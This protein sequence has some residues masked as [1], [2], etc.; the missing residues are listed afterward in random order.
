MNVI[1]KLVF[2]FVLASMLSACSTKIIQS[3]LVAVGLDSKGAMY[4]PSLE[5]DKRFIEADKLRLASELAILSN[6][7]YCDRTDLTL[8][9]CDNDTVLLQVLGGWTPI[10]EVEIAN[11]SKWY[12]LK[13]SRG[14]RMETWKKKDIDGKEVAAIVIRGTVFNEI[15][16]W[17][18]NLRWITRINPFVFDQYDQVRYNIRDIVKDLETSDRII[19]TGHSLGGG[20]AQ[21]AAYAS[22]RIKEVYAF[23]PSPVTGYFSVDSDEREKN[24]NEI[25]INRIYEV[26]EVLGYIRGFMRNLSP[27]PK[28]NPKIVELGFNY[29]RGPA[30]SQHSIDYLASKLSEMYLKVKPSKVVFGTK[31]SVETVS[32]NTKNIDTRDATVTGQFQ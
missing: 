24:K 16:D 27:I 32:L 4:V 19:V 28:D 9:H 30:V 13:N 2:V 14:M 31:A 3:P 6:N 26:G 1:S 15:D 17:Y 8:Q 11:P 25:K 29:D 21:Q 20:L 18:S 5:I 12:H 7:V 22:G 10:K 23:D